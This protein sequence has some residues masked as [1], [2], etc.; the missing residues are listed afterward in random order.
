VRIIGEITNFEGDILWNC[1]PNRPLDIAV[2][3]GDNRKAER[4]LNWKP[5]FS[6]MEGLKLTV[7]YWKERLTG[8]SQGMRESSDKSIVIPN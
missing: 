4:L 3:V 6:L 5:Q 1:I 2:L 8:D 7:E